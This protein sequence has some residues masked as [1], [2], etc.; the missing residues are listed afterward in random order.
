MPT[1]P[2]RTA[3][4]AVVS[5]LR[6]GLSV[7]IVCSMAGGA[8]A[9]PGG[10]RPF[11]TEAENLLTTTSSLTS[12]TSMPNCISFTDC[13]YDIVT[14]DGGD[15]ESLEFDIDG[16]SAYNA[17]F[18]NLDQALTGAGLTHEYNGITRITGIATSLLPGARIVTCSGSDLFDN[19]YTNKSFDFTDLTILDTFAYGRDG[20]PATPPRLCAATL[21][22]EEDDCGHSEFL[23]E[24]A[25]GDA[26]YD[27]RVRAVDALAALK[28]S[29]GMPSCQP[30]PTS[31][32]T[33]GNGEV[34][35]SDALAILLVAVGRAGLELSCPLPCNP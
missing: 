30:F 3:S 31:C 28:T 24:P 6:A 29:V 9:D 15:F 7:A 16:A 2:Y 23:P 25:C 22:C 33:D 19:D 17:V 10:L 11:A 8:F 5:C 32:D 4:T 13:D 1:I 34:T 35:G 20:E 12:S 18:C 21:R 14:T 27:G 26:V